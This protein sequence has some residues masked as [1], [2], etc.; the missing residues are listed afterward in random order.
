MHVQFVYNFSIY[1][2]EYIMIID[3]Y[4]ICTILLY[5]FYII[6]LLKLESYKYIKNYNTKNFSILYQV[7]TKQLNHV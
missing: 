6:L 3:Y 1:S 7:N 5:Y 4:D 2:S